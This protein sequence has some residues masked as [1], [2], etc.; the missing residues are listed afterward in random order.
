MAV[1]IQQAATPLT[2]AFALVGRFSV[3]CHLA[4]GNPKTHK[5]MMAFTL[6]ITHASN[7]LVDWLCCCPCGTVLSVLVDLFVWFC[8]GWIHNDIWINLVWFGGGVNFSNTL[9]HRA[10]ETYVTAHA[11]ERNRG[12]AVASILWSFPPNDNREIQ[13]TKGVSHA[14]C[15]ISK[16]TQQDGRGKK[17]A[18]LVWQAW[19]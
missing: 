4:S 7:I 1:Q 9:V 11:I 6:F 16:L 13:N 17:T 8:F 14:I 15:W 3:D 12:F 18:N 19:Q 2:D 10:I 5:T